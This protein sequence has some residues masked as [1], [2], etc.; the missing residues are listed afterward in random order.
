MWHQRMHLT[1]GTEV[2]HPRRGRGVVVKLE[3]DGTQRVHVKFN[4]A[5]HGTHRYKQQ[6]WDAKFNPFFI[7]TRLLSDPN[8]AWRLEVNSFVVAN[9]AAFSVSP[10]DSS[11]RYRSEVHAEYVAMTASLMERVFASSTVTPAT[12]MRACEVARHKIDG[13]M[14]DAVWEQI[15]AIDNPAV[16]CRVMVR[17]FRDISVAATVQSTSDVGAETGDCVLRQRELARITREH[18]DRQQHD[19]DAE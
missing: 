17:A 8:G 19:R 5:E 7:V 16:L 6:S 9:C 1:L 14:G 15:G 12:F 10:T 18:N 2:V 3:R 4:G 11:R 13:A